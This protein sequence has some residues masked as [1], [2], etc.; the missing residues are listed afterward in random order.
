MSLNDSHG[1]ILSAIRASF[2]NMVSVDLTLG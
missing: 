2:D 1:D